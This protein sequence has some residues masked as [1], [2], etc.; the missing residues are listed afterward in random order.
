MAEWCALSQGSCAAELL[1]GPMTAWGQFLPRRLDF[2]ASALPPEAAATVAARRDRFG[3]NVDMKKAANWR[4]TYDTLDWRYHLP[5]ALAFVI[6]A[7][8]Q[9]EKIKPDKGKKLWWD[10]GGQYK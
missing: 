4:H 1:P 2:A 10:N 9:G 5:S 3:P 6:F 7:F 8:R